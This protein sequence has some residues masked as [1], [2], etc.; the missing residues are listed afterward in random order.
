VLFQHRNLDALTRQKVS[1]HY[2]SR[3]TTNHTASRL[4]NLKCHICMA[5]CLKPLKFFD[6]EWIVTVDT[7]LK[8]TV[9]EGSLGPPVEESPR[10]ADASKFLTSCCFI[11][12]NNARDDN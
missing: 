6:A 12:G 9:E 10:T 2:A 8:A 1:E 11:G 3:P 5:S 4:Q 7:P